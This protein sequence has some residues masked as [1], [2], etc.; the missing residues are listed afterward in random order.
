VTTAGLD[1]DATAST[2]PLL[3]PSTVSTTST[4][5]PAPSATALGWVDEGLFTSRRSSSTSWLADPDGDLLAE[6]PHRSAFRVVTLLPVAVVLLLVLAYVGAAAAWPLDA[7][8]PA[9]SPAA[10]EGAAAAAA[11]PAWPSQGS[12]AVVVDGFG[13]PLASTRDATAIASITKIVTALMVLEQKP[14]KVGEQGPS[15]Q[16]TWADVATYRHMRN[17]GESVLKVPPVRSSMSEYQLLQGMLIGSAGNYAAKLAGSIWAND[18]DF[19]GA[20]GVWLEQ[21]G[22]SGITLVGPTGISEFNKADPASLIPL[23]KLAMANP[24]IAEIVGTKSITL[25]GA[26]LVQNTNELLAVPG[27]VGIK[28]GTLDS[29]DLLAAKDVTVG[30][31]KV[32]LYATALGQKND[33]ARIAATTAMFSELQKEL[34]PFPSV[35]RGTKV[36]TVTTEWGETVPIVTSSDADVVLWNG[37]KGTVATEFALKDATAKGDKVGSLSVAG[38]LDKASSDVVLAA[39]VDG[40]SFWWKLTHPLALLGA[41]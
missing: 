20:A 10:V 25:P 6:R 29:Y 17:A 18:D 5:V 3:V 4:T 38:P 8:R 21:H 34:T 9:V 24:V 19:A 32:R 31:T 11:T 27:V 30:D 16:I 1:G 12:A 22:L 33:K 41:K 36:G 14:L 35:R 26:G 37:A 28:T 39:D 13:A 40:P 23:G 15:Y 7:I 2:M